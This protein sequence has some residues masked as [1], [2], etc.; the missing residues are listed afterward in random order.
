MVSY[1]L[2]PLTSINKDDFA[3]DYNKLYIIFS[4]TFDGYKEHNAA[5]QTCS[6]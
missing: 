1:K 2:Y 6:S 5:S 3:E 4:T